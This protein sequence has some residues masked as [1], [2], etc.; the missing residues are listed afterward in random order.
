[1][2][3]LEDHL[4]PHELASLPE[5]PEALASGG[6]DQQP[7]SEHL[8]QC[9]ECSSLARMY[10]SLRS[11]RAPSTPA[12]GDAC[13]AQMLWLEFA[14]GM[15]SE[16]M[17]SLLSHAAGCNECA[18]ALKEAMQLMQPDELDATTEPLTGLASVTPAWQ[19]RVVGQI[20]AATEP[21]R[22]TGRMPST[23]KPLLSRYIPKNWAWITLPAATVALILAV[24][25]G[26]SLWRV[27][28]PS[29]ARLLALAYNKQRTLVLRSQAAIPFRWLRSRVGP[30]TASQ[31][32]PNSSN[33]AFVLSNTWTRPPTARTGTK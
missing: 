32:P 25:A 16:Q 6:P 1:M 23:A 30:A 18:V 28:H 26:I 29:D 22:L 7:L 19:R 11:V 3:S 4:S 15:Q 2:R 21:Y 17:P 8:Q 14:A 20:L 10:W 31:I 27:A 24:F 33:F 5:T 9:E 12:P 13:P